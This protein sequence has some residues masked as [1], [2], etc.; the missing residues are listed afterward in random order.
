V[1][2]RA[3]L[4]HISITVIV[5]KTG[6]PNSVIAFTYSERS[7]PPGYLDS[8]TA[9]LPSALIEMNAAT[10]SSSSPPSEFTIDHVV[11]HTEGSLFVKSS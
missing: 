4:P 7:I 2:V 8:S 3:Y 11:G 9:M 1:T 10:S 5:L 6:V